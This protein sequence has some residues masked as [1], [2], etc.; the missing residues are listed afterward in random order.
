MY[1][2]YLD[3]FFTVAGAT[4]I[5]L[6][7][8]PS[9]AKQ[10]HPTWQLEVFFPAGAENLTSV[11]QQ[12]SRTRSETA[13]KLHMAQSVKTASEGSVPQGAAPASMTHQHPQQLY[14]IEANL[15]PVNNLII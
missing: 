13:A 6:S 2:L 14:F 12:D 15:F 7:D 1:H 11:L 9:K 10:P 4:E 3:M 8:K 5:R